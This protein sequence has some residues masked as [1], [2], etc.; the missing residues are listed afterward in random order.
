M[1]IFNFV[2]IINYTFFISSAVE[3]LGKYSGA[4]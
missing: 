2:L 3:A 4:F 1:K